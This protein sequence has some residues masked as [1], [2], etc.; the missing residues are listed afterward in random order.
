VKRT[1]EEVPAHK[2][3]LAVPFYMR[4]WKETKTADGV[5]VTQ[6]AIGMDQAQ[7]WLRSEKI[8][9]VF[10]PETGNMY[11]EKTVGQDTQKLWIEDATSMKSR[12]DLAQSYGLA[13]VAAWRRGFENEAV[14]KVIEDYSK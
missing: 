2:L 11:A 3:V 7:E 1:L 13:G 10:D 4:L 5:K 6:R 8:T 12:T 9:P 14:W